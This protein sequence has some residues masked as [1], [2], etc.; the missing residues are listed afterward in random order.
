MVHATAVGNHDERHTAIGRKGAE[1]CP[2]GHDD[3]DA[4]TVIVMRRGPGKWEAGCAA[5]PPGTRAF[6]E[7]REGAIEAWNA[8][9]RENG[10]GR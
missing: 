7:T 4:S 8:G 5:C 10:R 1:D 3:E 2:A 9:E 6:G